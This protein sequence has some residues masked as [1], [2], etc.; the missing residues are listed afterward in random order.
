[1]AI[2]A[3]YR[4]PGIREADGPD[5]DLRDVQIARAG[6][7]GDSTHIV[8]DGVISDARRHA[9]RRRA[10][11]ALIVAGAALAMVGSAFAV[12][13]GPTD[14]PAGS[15]EPDQLGALTAPVN[16]AEARVVEMWARI[17]NGWVYVYD[18]GRVLSLPDSGPITERHLSPYGVDL[19]R[20]GSLDLVRLLR[21]QLTKMPAEVWS[22]STPR[23]YRPSEYAVCSFN[24]VPEPTTEILSDVG[25]IEG[26]LPEQVRA[27]LRAGHVRSF[28]DDFADENRHFTGPDGYHSESG[29]GVDCFVLGV[30][31]TQAVWAHTRPQRGAPEGDNEFRRSDTTFGV[32]NGADGSEFTVFAVPIM[33]HGGWVIWGG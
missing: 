22:D 9:K 19:I 33:P 31:E 28:T 14:D 13:G 4:P 5:P 25:L 27:L 12:F 6:T 23:S 15:P 7:V 26:R 1:M 18:D 10:G 32:L 2:S 3:L 20:E 8:E 16:P 29:P 17:H 11:Y 24:E 30:R 21:P